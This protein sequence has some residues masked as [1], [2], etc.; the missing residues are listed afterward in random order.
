[1]GFVVTAGYVTVETAVPGGRAAI[2]I[3]RGT[4][5]P[6][7]VPAEQVKVLLDR[8]DI[9]LVLTEPDG[10]EGLADGTIADVLDRVGGDP[11]RARAALRA[12]QAR[13]VKARSTLLRDLAAIAGE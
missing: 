13:G 8:G 7:D 1:M 6:A 3:P 5:L 4:A 11:E 9:E 2:D 10:D 12:E